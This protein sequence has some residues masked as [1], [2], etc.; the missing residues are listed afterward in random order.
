MPPRY[1]RICEPFGPEQRQGL[2]LYHV[3]EPERWAAMCE[4]VNGVHSGGSTRAGQSFLW[5]PQN[6]E[7]RRAQLA[8]IRH[9]AST[10]CRT[11]P[12]NI[13]AI[14]SRSFALVS[15][16]RHGRYSRHPEGDIGAK[17]IP[18]ATR[19]RYY[20]TMTTGAGRC[21]SVRTNPHYQRY[22]ERMKSKR[23]EWGSYAAAI[24]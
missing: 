17:D 18:S 6:S 16:E 20:S 3:V 24:N 14:K 21:H 13:T 9:A 2:W 11:P 10:A 19:A 8:G 4:R 23:K 7:T 1:M 15:E 5:P 22:S 12:Q